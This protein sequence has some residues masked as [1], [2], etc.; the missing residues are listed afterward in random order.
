MA[1]NV[2]EARR[3]PRGFATIAPA[4]PSA[5]YDTYW[6]FAAERQR[7]FF[8]RALGNSVPTR[9]PILAKHKFTNAYRAS[10]RVSQYLIRR[11][12]YEGEQAHRE[13]FFRTLLFKF[14]NR[15]ETWELLVRHFEVP[16][17]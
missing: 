6:K 17:S 8:A 1:R 11:V 7:I 4:K 10:D 16:T 14:F 12:L 15:I 9:D 3:T 13:I 2:N 5:V